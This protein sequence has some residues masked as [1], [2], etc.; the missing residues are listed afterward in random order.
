MLRTAA[1]ITRAPSLYLDA[2]TLHDHLELRACAPSAIP[3]A[4]FRMPS[5]PFTLLGGNIPIGLHRLALVPASI[6]PM[7]RHTS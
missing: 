3:L 6:G 1:L 7:Y 5:V 4:A 2:S